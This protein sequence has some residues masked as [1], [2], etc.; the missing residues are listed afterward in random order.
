MQC[1]KTFSTD[2]QGTDR[3]HITFRV[4]EHAGAEGG[5]VETVAGD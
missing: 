4:E 5:G 2:A 1:A 3:Y